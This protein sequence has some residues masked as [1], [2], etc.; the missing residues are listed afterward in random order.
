MSK[1]ARY[2]NQ[3]PSVIAQRDG[4]VCRA[5]QGDNRNIFVNQSVIMYNRLQ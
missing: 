3:V 1:E 2:F 4:L 5:P